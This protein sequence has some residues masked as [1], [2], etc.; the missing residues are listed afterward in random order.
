MLL[1]IPK[2]SQLPSIIGKSAVGLLVKY[3]ALADKQISDHRQ[4]ERE[5]L[6]IIRDATSGRDMVAEVRRRV[7]ELRQ[8]RI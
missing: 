2:R 4:F 1:P 3:L 7:L 8:D 6:A 5:V